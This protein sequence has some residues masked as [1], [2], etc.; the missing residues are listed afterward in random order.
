MK[1]TCL[2]SGLWA[3]LILRLLSSPTLVDTKNDVWPQGN[4]AALIE[5]GHSQELSTVILKGLP[6]ENVL[7]KPE[8]V[9][10]Y[11]EEVCGTAIDTFLPNLTYRAAV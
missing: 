10:G 1:L 4:N 7:D 6:T 8:E 5:S 11:G 3:V 2:H 9:V